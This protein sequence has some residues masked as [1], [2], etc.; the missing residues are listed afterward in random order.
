M[1]AP[2]AVP[3]RPLDAQVRPFIEAGAKVVDRT[4][5]RVVLAHD[6]LRF[7]TEFRMQR[8]LLARIRH[9][10]VST[11][12]PAMSGPGHDVTLRLRI[13]KSRTAGW[14]RGGIG[15]ELH[16]PAVAKLVRTVDLTSFSATWHAENRTW[17]VQIEPYAGAHLRVFFPPITYG[18]TLRGGEA[19]TLIDALH[20][21]ATVLTHH[22]GEPR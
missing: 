6:S 11:V 19:A 5:D 7:A 16:G 15:P 8:M 18:I 17:L 3:A 12:V 10:R 4:A 20:E 2:A 14:E 21:T 1:T 13:H 22:P 9:L